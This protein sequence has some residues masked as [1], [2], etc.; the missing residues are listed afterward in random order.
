MTSKAIGKGPRRRRLVDAAMG[1]YLDWRDECTAVTDAYRRWADAG[2][3]DAAIA[4][5]A[6]EVALDREERTSLLYAD[7][8]ERL[9]GLAATER[10]PSA[11]WEEAVR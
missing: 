6:Y 5:S 8:I 9:G 11:A 1:A 2:E 4:W 10:G 3:G 7:R